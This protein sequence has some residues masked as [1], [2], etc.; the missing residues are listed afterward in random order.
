MPEEK[1]KYAWMER[2]PVRSFIPTEPM[3][4]PYHEVVL[5]LPERRD[6]E[7]AIHDA[8]EAEYLENYTPDYILLG[9]EYY[10][11]LARAYGGHG[12]GR[13]RFMDVPVLLDRRLGER[14]VR[15]MCTPEHEQHKYLKGCGQ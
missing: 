13:F 9:G 10:F 11:S 14:E 4:I 5:T 12:Y 15:I 2:T 8:L 7:V 3:S 6:V 1:R